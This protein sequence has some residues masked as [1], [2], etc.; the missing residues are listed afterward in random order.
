MWYIYIICST[1]YITLLNLFNYAYRN[2]S[3]PSSC[4]LMRWLRDCLPVDLFLLTSR[5]VQ[6]VYEPSVCMFQCMIQIKYICTMCNNYLGMLCTIPEYHNIAHSNEFILSISIYMLC[7]VLMLVCCPSPSCTI[8]LWP[9]EGI[10]EGVWP[11]GGQQTG[12]CSTHTQVACEGYRSGYHQVSLAHVPYL[13]DE[14]FSCFSVAFSL[15]YFLF[16]LPVLHQASPFRHSLF[17]LT[18]FF[19]P[20]IIPET[21][22]LKLCQQS[23][24]SLCL[25]FPGTII[26]GS[27]SLRLS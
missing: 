19:M 12:G 14:L 22:Q 26:I 27:R 18:I 9:L 16:L 17:P 20:I 10:W 24:V 5:L 21:L 2:T 1:I 11:V 13:F 15:L 25:L 3:R 7:S 6:S 23:W 4:A 8:D